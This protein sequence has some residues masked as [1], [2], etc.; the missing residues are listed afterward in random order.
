[1]SHRVNI[2][3][4]A[5]AY[6]RVEHIDLSFMDGVF[7]GFLGSDQ[8][9][10]GRGVG[11][12]PDGYGPFDPHEDRLE[13]IDLL[14]LIAGVARTPADLEAQK[15]KKQVEPDFWVVGDFLSDRVIERGHGTI[16]PAEVGLYGLAAVYGYAAQR[17]IKVGSIISD[18]ESRASLTMPI[19]AKDALISMLN[20]IDEVLDGSGKDIEDGSLAGMLDLVAGYAKGSIVIPVSDFGHDIDAK[21]TEAGIIVDDGTDEWSRAIAGVKLQNA[22]L[23]LEIVAA[24]AYESPVT[25][26]RGSRMIRL[27]G[28]SRVLE[29]KQIAKQRELYRQMTA[30]VRDGVTDAM[31]RSGVFSTEISVNSSDPIRDIVVGLEASARAYSA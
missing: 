21:K 8:F 23:P 11:K 9:N 22:V 26:E 24:D 29:E 28:G 4:I 27:R 17:G 6:D 5:A 31:H 20:G 2:E 3:N 25:E 15:Y 16:S 19:R 1:M 30:A 10:L 14:P 18:G 12:T 13:D 7:K